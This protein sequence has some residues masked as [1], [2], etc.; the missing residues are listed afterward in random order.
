MNKIEQWQEKYQ[1]AKSSWS[2]KKEELLKYS[3]L[4]EGTY[5]IETLTSWL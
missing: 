3:A 2:G 4:Y 5:E 1:K